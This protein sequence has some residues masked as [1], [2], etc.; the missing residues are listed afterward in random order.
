[1]HLQVEV[2]PD[3][4]NTVSIT[5]YTLDFP[6]DGYIPEEIEELLPR[7]YNFKYSETCTVDII[8]YISSE[9]EQLINAYYYSHDEMRD[10]IRIPLPKDG[11]YGVSHIV[12][13]TIQWYQ[14]LTQEE[15]KQYRV[16]YVTDGFAIYK[17]FGGTLQKVNVLE[18]VEF[19]I[20]ETTV[21][22]ASFNIFTM[23]KLKHCYDAV[24]HKILQ[25]YTG[26]CGTID[27]DLRFKRDF[28]WMTINVIKYHLEW[29]EYSSAQLVLEGIQ[30][31]NGLCGDLGSYN[32]KKKGGCGC[33]G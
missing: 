8:I 29:G 7:L 15:L 3:F 33:G 10:Q 17:V 13:P 14:K 4:H 5:D 2:K 11:Y 21:S 1:M 26:R 31:C 24:A 6:E 20:D 12:L 25:A 22:K 30:G 28:L 9:G 32:V 18:L 23:D 27:D 19:N 16:V